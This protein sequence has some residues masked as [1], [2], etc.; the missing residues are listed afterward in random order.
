[1]K[2]I[3]KRRFTIKFTNLK[4]QGGFIF[5]ASMLAAMLVLSYVTVHYLALQAD[6]IAF[7][8]DKQQAHSI[9]TYLHSL[10]NASI[11]SDALA[12]FATAG[13]P[14]ENGT[15][16]IGTTWLKTAACGGTQTSE[17]LF[18]EFENAPL[19]GDDMQY[20]TE[21]TNDG[22]QMDI[23]V[24]IGN[25][26]RTR[27]FDFAGEK[28]TERS[29]RIA[30]IAAGGLVDATFQGS[31][32]EVDCDAKDTGI[33]TMNVRY[34]TGS[35][36][37]IRRNGTNS[38]TATIDWDGQNIDGMNQLET[39]TVIDR[40]DNA[41]VLDLNG[42]SILQSLNVEDAT[43][44]DATVTN[45]TITDATITTA[46]V[47]NANITTLTGTDLTYATGAI[48]DLTV[49][50]AT[51][52][53][54]LTQNDATVVNSF[55]G[56]V[57]S[58]TGA[59]TVSLE[60]GSIYLTGAVVD[61]NDESMFFNPGGISRTQDIRLTSRGGVLLSAMLPNYV[62]KGAVTIDGY[63]SIS[64]PNCGDGFGT[65]AARVVI[66]WQNA[67]EGIAQNLQVVNNYSYRKII[68]SSSSSAWAVGMATY[69]YQNSVWNTY[70]SQ[71]VNIGLANIYCYYP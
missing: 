34:N 15:V 71:G 32:T 1:M 10:K 55:A 3:G 59:N 17:Y 60:S 70:A 8:A 67:Q 20:R 43:I 62:N 56:G 24:E 53:T 7:E 61:E 36:D 26:A 18:C 68:V 6:E 47:D 5:Q 28:A 65:D 29:C 25:T 69:D 27:G 46:N 39:S 30:R 23:S 51:V 50:N 58:G 35:D 64:K 44:T 31:T 21:I 66:N 14:F 40:D 41:Y 12:E 45:A 38:P 54:Q 52:Q 16:H 11:T 9:T 63:A 2:R 57:K 33:I 48:T 42:N 37:Y 13:A 49:D 22:T 4:K 19:I